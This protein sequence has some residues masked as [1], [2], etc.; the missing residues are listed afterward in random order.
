MINLQL[1]DTSQPVRSLSN[2]TKKLFDLEK[3]YLLRHLIMH[4]IAPYSFLDDKYYLLLKYYQRIGYHL[5]LKNPTTFNDKLNWIKLYDRNP[6]YTILSD[7]YLVRDYIAQTAGPQYLNTLI[8]V[9]NTPQEIDWGRLPDRIVLKVNHGCK[10]NILC[11]DK[12]RLDIPQA[13]SKLETWLADNGYKH[14]RE[15]P[16]KNIQPRILCEE[17]LDGDPQW[18]L[19]D[20]KFFCFNGEPAY[21]AVDYDRFTYHTQF[22][23]DLNWVRQP[24]TQELPTPEVDAPRPQKLDE[25]TRVARLLAKDIP[26]CRVDFYQFDDRVLVGEI[27]L[28]PAAGFKKITPI[29]YEYKLGEMI[30]LKK[31]TI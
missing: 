7:K 11:K 9:Y 19:L 29:E 14:A 8:A 5:N 25:M 2:L 1:M 15:W 17:Y 13:V 27:T 31:F 10:F 30:K 22:F 20:Y 4:R 28:F 16:Y 12:A 21:I 26:F 3:W 23:Y 6:F 24:F 18:G